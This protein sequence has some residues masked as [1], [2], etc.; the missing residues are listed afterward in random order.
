MT[1]SDCYLAS[2]LECA[3]EGPA[4]SWWH[5]VDQLVIRTIDLRSTYWG[6]IINT[7]LILLAGTAAEVQI[8]FRD[9]LVRDRL[10][11][12]AFWIVRV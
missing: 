1:V 4:T 6:V 2:G 11:C 9:Y 10:V 5:I 12:V 3:V 8:N 7:T